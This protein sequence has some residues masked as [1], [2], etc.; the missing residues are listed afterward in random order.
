MVILLS[1][2]Q[3]DVMVGPDRG[4]SELVGRFGNPSR[5]VSRI[6]F[7]ERVQALLRLAEETA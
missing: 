1:A 3:P 4:C 6:A 5:G 7:V 2:E